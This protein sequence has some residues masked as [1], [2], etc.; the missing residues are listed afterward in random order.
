MIKGKAVKGKKSRNIS[1]NT[2]AA[3]A[4]NPVRTKLSLLN[5]SY[6][7]NYLIISPSSPTKDLET[8]SATIPPT[9]PKC[10]KSLRKQMQSSRKRFF[11]VD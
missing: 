10:V 4:N 1:S 2:M 8:S 6:A 11:N 7:I 9:S 3:P 5:V